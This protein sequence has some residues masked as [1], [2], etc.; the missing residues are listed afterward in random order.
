MRVTPAGTNTMSIDVDCGDE[1]ERM[2]LKVIRVG[3]EASELARQLKDG[4]RV[5]VVGRLRMARAKA[6]VEVIA[7]CVMIEPIARRLG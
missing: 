7:D 2:V 4:G 5:S 6:Q 1:G 3:A